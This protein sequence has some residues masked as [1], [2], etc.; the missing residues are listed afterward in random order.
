[1]ANFKFVIIFIFF[2]WQNPELYLLFM[3]LISMAIIWNIILI[4]KSIPQ[5]FW[6]E[7]NVV[8]EKWQFID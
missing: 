4:V 2:K 3:K 5:D 7:F 6:L 8:L 1:M